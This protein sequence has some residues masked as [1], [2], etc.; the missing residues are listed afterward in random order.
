MK[1]MNPESLVV[2]LAD[3]DD[4]RS[5]LRAARAI[6]DSW[7]RRVEVLEAF[8]N[9]AAAP[10]LARSHTPARA[11]ATD[12]GDVAP[13]QILDLVVDA[14]QQAGR[15]I[16]SKDVHALLVAQGRDVSAASVANS[17][18]YAARKAARL[19]KLPGR[20]WYAPWGY[21]VAPKTP[22]SNTE[23]PSSNAEGRT[24]SAA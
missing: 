15:P 19:D 20:G 14:V 3:P 9:E 10:V 4:V 6:R 12:N 23:S 5:K 16:R 13:G 8:T 7:I 11:S 17:L 2:D 24:E 22:D 1:P 18:Y 21:T